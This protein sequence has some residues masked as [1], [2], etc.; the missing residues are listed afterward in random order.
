MTLPL[1]DALTP[2]Q[3]AI[4]DVLPLLP[5]DGVVLFP[6]MLLPLAVSGDMWVKLV[7]DVALGDKFVGVF[8]RT[9]PGEAFDPNGLAGTGTAAQIVRML[10][11]PD[12]G[13]QVLLQGQRRIQIEQLLSS[14]PYPMARVRMLQSPQTESLELEGLV[15]S[16]RTTFQQI[17]QASPSLPDELALVAA[18]VPEAGRL[19]DLIAANLALSP[20]NRQQVLETLDPA[21][22]IRHVLGFLEREREIEAIGQRTR[23]EFSRTQREYVLRQQLEQIRRELGETDERGAEIT[24]LRKQLAEA[25]LPEEAHREAEREL[26]RLERMPPGAAEASVTRTYLDWLLGLP[27]NTGTDDNLDLALARQVLDEDHYDLEE[28]K[29]RILEYLAV[30]ELRRAR[31]G[32]DG[33][34]TKGAILCFVGPPG[35]GKT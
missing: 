32:E 19:A 20:E 27:W 16:A 33:L 24:E 23:E 9:T 28:I 30:R 14:E 3:P 35:V 1:P 18:N 17:V 12:N 10:R 13:I 5:I 2:E 4:P 7:D 6:G 11:T 31:L 21:E 34:T 22:R 15:R 29:G 8:L 26:E 25:Q